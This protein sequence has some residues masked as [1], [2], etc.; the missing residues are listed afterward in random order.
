MMMKKDALVR[1]MIVFSSA[2]LLFGCATQDL[3]SENPEAFRQCEFYRVRSIE[4]MFI[5]G[6]LTNRSGEAYFESARQYSDVEAMYNSSIRLMQAHLITGI[7]DDYA[8]AFDEAEA[9]AVAFLDFMDQKIDEAF[10]D[11]TSRGSGSKAATAPAGVLDVALGFIPTYEQL[12][13]RE[14]GNREALKD[15][16][17]D[18]YW[19]SISEIWQPATEKESGP[20]GN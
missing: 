19:P 1:M 15:L 17:D 4:R 7:V 13:A 11:T 12:E 8:T 18:L 2:S 20:A 5:L 16:L 14:T 3:V 10:A 6:S 9:S